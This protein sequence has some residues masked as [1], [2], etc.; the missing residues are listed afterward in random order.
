M[1]KKKIKRYAVDLLE[2]MRLDVRTALNQSLP[3]ID[4]AEVVSTSPEIVIEPYHTDVIYEEDY[5][6]FNID[7]DSLSVGDTVVIGR[8]PSNHP[9]VL[10]ISDGN[11]ENPLSD[12]ELAG[13]IN[14]ANLLRE[15]TSHW[16]ASVES[17][18]DLPLAGN[19]DGDLRYSLTDNI[20]YRWQAD[21]VTWVSID[22]GLGDYLPLTG[23]TLSGDLIID[24]GAS[25]TL[26]DGPIDDTDAVNKIYVD[27]LVFGPSFFP[28]ASIDHTDSP[29]MAQISDQVI[30]VDCSVAPVTVNLPPVHISGKVYDIKDA[31]GSASI[32]NIL[33]ISADGDTVDG[34]PSHS[35]ITDYQ[36][37]Q[38]VSNGSN[39][40]IL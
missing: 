36:S 21:T 19:D 6:M 31:S 9:I 16:K 32:N 29:Y 25:I 38:L 4:L 3:A 20:I 11:N 13:F 1:A 27:S 10:G 18:S 12:P 15:N 23:G 33:I 24:T 2:E 35:L 22:I 34:S 17:F 39:W 26:T 37:I 40:F 14:N 30:L 5:L 8:S 7:P 28:A